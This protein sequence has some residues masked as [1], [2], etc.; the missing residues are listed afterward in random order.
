M[1][2]APPQHTRNVIDTDQQVSALAARVVVATRNLTNPDVRLPLPDD[3]PPLMNVDYQFH[4]QE[5]LARRLAA[6]GET[7]QTVERLTIVFPQK[8]PGLFPDHYDSARFVADRLETQLRAATGGRADIQRAEG[9]V[10]MLHLD[11]SANQ[12]SLHALTKRQTYHYNPQ[13]QKMPLA[14]AEA[15]HEGER[16]Y[17]VLTDNQVEQG[18]TLAN[19]ASYVRHNG[20][21]L[22]MGVYQR[23]MP[24]ISPERICI[25]EYTGPALSRRFAK[26][27]VPVNLKVIGDRLVETAAT[28]GLVIKRN[29]ALS[30]VEDYLN[31][32]GQSLLSMTH[33][34]SKRLLSSLEQGKIAYAD[35]AG[36]KRGMK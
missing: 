4:L 34:E 29:Q 33:N 23:G 22:L 36:L 28:D 30:N 25:K 19:L 20:G 21:T 32:C 12:S 1:T 10:E 31:R 16:H 15:A 3:F 27:A 9:L 6:Y 2:Q 17:V 7:L 8:D 11:R 14:F 13:Y 18:T 5:L 35:L 26:A 24:F